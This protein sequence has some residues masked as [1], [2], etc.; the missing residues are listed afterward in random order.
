MQ[1]KSDE[2]SRGRLIVITGLPS[3]G[4]TEL[5]WTRRRRGRQYECVQTIG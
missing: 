4:K 2:V 3:I 1:V 5:A